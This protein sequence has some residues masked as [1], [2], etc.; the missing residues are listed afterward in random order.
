MK[1]TP[2]V[3][4][5]MTSYNREKYIAEAIQSVIDSTYKDFE[6][7]IVDDRSKDETVA[8]ARQ[9]V[10]K[11][12]RITIYVNEINLG[13][14]PNRNKAASY[15]RGKYLKYV[16]ADDKIYKDSLRKF[17]EAMELNNDCTLGLSLEYY[18]LNNK[19]FTKIK[20][21]DALY[22]FFKY[23]GIFHCGPTGAIIRRDIFDKVG[24][25]SG[26]RLVSDLKMWIEL[27]KISP[28]LILEKDLV[29]W[30]IHDDQQTTIGKDNDEEFIKTFRVTNKSLFS[31]DIPLN[32]EKRVSAFYSV[33][34][35][36]VVKFFIL[37]KE[38][39]LKYALRVY[40]R[41]FFA[42]YYK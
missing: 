7:I 14:Y 41:L 32:F 40:S 28:L 4:V 35:Y 15:A 26:E 18:N 2:M 3:S 22:S 9:F 12:Q 38:K 8:I 17:V 37:K 25:F 21:E 6:L 5:L 36:F 34:K 11:D 39:S 31:K 42:H 24:K 29:Y 13:D 19:P 27:S 16:D 1:Y 10:E 30:R 20:S 23:K 33:Y